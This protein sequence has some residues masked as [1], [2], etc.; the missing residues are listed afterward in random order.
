MNKDIAIK[1]MSA[2]F[3]KDEELFNIF[4]VSFVLTFTNDSLIIFDHV[5]HY[6]VTCFIFVMTFV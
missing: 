6:Y 3:I 1:D 4:K 5:K 2:L